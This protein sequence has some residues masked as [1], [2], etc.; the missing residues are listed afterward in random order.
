ML[1]ITPPSPL[2]FMSGR[3]A[4]VTMK[5]P[6]RI[7]LVTVRHCAS[8]ISANGTWARMPALLTSTSSR[9]KRWRIL[10]T[11]ARTAVS[12][13]MS[14]RQTS[15]DTPSFSISAA[16]AL[17]S[18]SVLRAC[19]TTEAPSRAASSNVARPM[20][21]TDPVTNTTF[22]ANGLSDI[23]ASKLRSPALWH[24]LPYREKN[25]SPRSHGDTE[26]GSRRVR[27]EPPRLRG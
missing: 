5:V 19:T 1:T 20:R 14:A 7:T 6:S 25:G 18:S 3:H 8:V 17:A 24:V 23:H 13:V 21:R 9:P 12:S 11:M 10:S 15:A 22:P 16:V 4:E 27:F 26:G 2:A